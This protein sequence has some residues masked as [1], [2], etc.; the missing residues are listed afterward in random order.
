MPRAT[1]LT[2]APTQTIVADQTP[3]DGAPQIN[4]SG[5]DPADP[6]SAAAQEKI[7]LLR[8]RADEAHRLVPEF[9]VL[10]DLNDAKIKAERTLKRLLDHPRDG[11]GFGLPESDARVKA[12]TKAV[13]KAAADARRLAELREIRSA[14]WQAASSALR[15]VESFLQTRPGNTTLAEFD[16]P[17][18]KLN[19]GEDILSAIERLRRRGRELSADLHSVRSAPFSSAHAKRR[20]RE[21]IEQLAQRGEP[22]VAGLI[23]HGDCRIEQ[24]FPKMLARADVHNAGP[25]AAGCAAYF[26]LVDPTALVAALL[27]D[28]MVKWFDALID[29]EADDKA[30]LDGPERAR[31]EAEILSDI[32]ANDRDLAA[33]IWMGQA[34]GLPVEFG[35]CSP[36]A[37]LNLRLTTQPR[38][39]NGHTSPE[40]ATT[41]VGVGR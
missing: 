23:E 35:D 28:A 13:E 26:E 11:D 17:Q 37:I 39:S 22:N 27:K 4:V 7:F 24:L 6:L 41:M 16:G 3:F 12:A 5:Y 40:H 32:L 10:Q 2:P 36:L 20:L 34:Q 21:M 33:L 25:K 15:N 1:S 14:Q 38:A 30:A 18:P 19:K 9:L 8:R 29:A 31:R